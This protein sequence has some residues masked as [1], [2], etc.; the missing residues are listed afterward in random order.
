MPHRDPVSRVTAVQRFT[1]VADPPA[2]DET[3]TARLRAYAHHREGLKGYG[4][5]VTLRLRGR[6]GCYV[7]L[8]EWHGM[9]ELLR[10]THDESFLPHLAAV[11][12][13]ATA[14]HELTVSVGAM[15]AAVPLTGAR[16]LVLVDA[17]VG[18]ESSRFE[19]DFGALVGSCVTAR[20]YGGSDL[21][22]S[23]V[24]PRRYTG[25]LWWR[26]AASH[27]RTLA[28]PGYLDRR[29]KLTTTAA[30]S[31]AHAEPLAGEAH[32]GPLAGD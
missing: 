31:E 29:A 28:D 6:P 1:A 25:L 11:T 4:S 24:D 14:E 30:V 15:P 10:A 17:L 20:G 12:A 32:A 18:D 3:L 13:L 27:A 9:N 2:G 16:R 26:D 5:G 21:L 22:R 7:R 8:D 23:V 19:M